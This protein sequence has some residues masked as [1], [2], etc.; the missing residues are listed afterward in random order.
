M[1]VVALLG[2]SAVNQ[3]PHIERKENRRQGGTVAIHRRF[4]A[5]AMAFVTAAKESRQRG[6]RRR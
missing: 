6:T 3:S 4:P 5:A 2:L 1:P